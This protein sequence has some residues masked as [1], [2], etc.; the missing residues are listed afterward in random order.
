MI[1][2]EN[3]ENSRDERSESRWNDK[4]IPIRS[5]FDLVIVAAAATTLTSDPKQ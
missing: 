5:I 2:E 4:T 3:I 1:T